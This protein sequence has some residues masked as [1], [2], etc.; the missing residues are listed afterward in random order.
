MIEL[1]FFKPSR[2]VV[3][4]AFGVAAV[5]AMAWLLG[6]SR[7]PQFSGTNAAAVTTGVKWIRFV[8]TCDRQ[9]PITVQ[10]AI[11]DPASY[12]AILID[13]PEPGPDRQR[14]A[15]MFRVR[16]PIAGIN[17]GYF[18]SRFQPVGLLLIDGEIRSPLSTNP[19]LSAIVGVDAAGQI[20]L[21]PTRDGYDGLRSAIQAGP[22]LIDPGSSV[23][24]S[25]DRPPRTRR[26]VIAVTAAGQILMISTSDASLYDI[27]LI[28]TKLGQVLPGV[29]IE[30]AANLDGGPSCAW[31]LAGS[32][33]ASA[34]TE[35][36]PVRNYLLALPPGD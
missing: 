20:Q 22:W 12:R 26:S 19:P 14:L 21:R 1:S 7:L 36:G 34:V 28:L 16:Q 25:N 13:Q 3:I 27:A 31:E 17:G 15:D 35:V 2:W 9:T 4:A 10:C 18:D 32:T 8:A 30:R 29:K 6:P 24:I 33:K 11:F 5:L 23:G